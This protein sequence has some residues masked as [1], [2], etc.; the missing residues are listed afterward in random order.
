MRRYRCPALERLDL[1]ATLIS[2]TSVRALAALKN[3]QQ[4]DLYGSQVSDETLLAVIR[5]N[6][7]L[8]VLG[9]KY[10]SILTVDGTLTALRAALNV[11]TLSLRRAQWRSL[12]LTMFLLALV[13]A[14]SG[15]EPLLPH[16]RFFE[17]DEPKQDRH[18]L[19]DAIFRVRRARPLLDL[20]LVPNNTWHKP[21]VHI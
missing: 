7:R 1:G 19:V 5:N 2:D 16:L 6:P 9:L 15:T 21:L 8:E 18:A 12:E 20:Q 13:E 11:H 10:C 4:L 17:I 14:P 3:L